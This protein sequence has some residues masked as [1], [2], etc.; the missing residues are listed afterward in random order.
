MLFSSRDNGPVPC[1]GVPALLFLLRGTAP[2][3]CPEVVS[4]LNPGSM[5]LQLAAISPYVR[6]ARV[7]EAAQAAFLLRVAF[8]EVAALFAAIAT[9]ASY[10]PARRATRVDPLIALRAE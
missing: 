6:R 1:S 8:A 9:L 4:G 10:I 7:T 5:D 2:V 3:S